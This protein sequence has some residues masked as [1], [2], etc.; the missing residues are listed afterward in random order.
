MLRAIRFATPRAS[1]M[2]TLAEDGWRLVRLGVTTVE[3]V[4][5]VTTAKEVA[6]PTKKAA[7]AGD[8][9]ETGR[10]ERRA[11]ARDKA[12]PCRVFQYRALQARRRD[13]RRRARGW[14]PA[15]SLSPDGGRGLAPDQSGGKSGGKAERERLPRIDGGVK[16]PLDFHSA[17]SRQ[18]ISARALENFTRLLSSL[19]AAGVPLSRALVILHKEASN[20]AAAGKVEGDS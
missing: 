4:L 3:E 12:T 19:L 16:L 1:G 15:G 20:P 2:R 6:Q 8:E 9:Q 13:C 5:S 14:R 17:R 7:S 18:K 10:A 11:S